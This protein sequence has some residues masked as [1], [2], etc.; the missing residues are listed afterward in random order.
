MQGYSNM[1]RA[2]NWFLA[3]M[4][5]NYPHRQETHEMYRRCFFAGW[6]ASAGVSR[7]EHL[8]RAVLGECPS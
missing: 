2:F 7:W 1:E 6:R 8:K 5:Q 4:G 3:T